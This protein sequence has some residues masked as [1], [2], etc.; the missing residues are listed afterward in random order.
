MQK[1]ESTDASTFQD[2][3]P[4]PQCQTRELRANSVEPCIGNPCDFPA[5]SSP[6]SLEAEGRLRTRPGKVTGRSSMT[7]TLSMALKKH[8]ERQVRDD[9]ANTHKTPGD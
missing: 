8:V 2:C 1:A 3:L 5:T 6:C 9:D 4:D 7:R